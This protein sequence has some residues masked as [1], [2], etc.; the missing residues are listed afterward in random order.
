MSMSKEHGWEDY[1]CHCGSL[2][3]H[4]YVGFG[5]DRQ[6]NLALMKIQ[7]AGGLCPEHREK[8]ER[9]LSFLF[10]EDKA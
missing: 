5:L 9:G 7:T 2:A 10:R 4:F 6:D 3:G 8:M 1:F